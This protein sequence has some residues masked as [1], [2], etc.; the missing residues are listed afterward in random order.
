M[1]CFNLNV[2]RKDKLLFAI[3]R[4]DSLLMRVGLVCDVVTRRVTTWWF[5]KDGKALFDKN[6]RPLGYKI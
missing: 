6:G 3:G 1:G 5:S 4:K 2:T